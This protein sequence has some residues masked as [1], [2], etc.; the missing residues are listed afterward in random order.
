MG[1]IIFRVFVGFDNPA[2]PLWLEEGVASYQEK[3]TYSMA[4]TFV[5]KAIEKGNFITLERL[6]GFSSG[7]RIPDEA[8]Q[9]FYIE[10]FSIVDFLIKEFGKDKFV[11]F[12]QDLRDKKNL[13][14]AIAS[15]YPFSNIQ[16][17]DE[18]WEK[19]LKSG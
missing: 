8:A 19:H 15:D 4:N 14:R 18:A 11:S 13:E 3:L 1:H 16:E 2:I 17:L 12:C 7:S 5:R 10:S 9:L 6:S